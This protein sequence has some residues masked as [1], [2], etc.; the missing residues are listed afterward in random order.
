MLAQAR[1]GVYFSPMLQLSCLYKIVPGRDT[2]TDPQLGLWPSQLPAPYGLPKL[3]R[4]ATVYVVQTV[5]FSLA[6][7]VTHFFMVSRSD[8]L[9]EHFWMR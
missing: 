1:S 6:D 4:I 7:L 3:S 5:H 8:T 9:Q 2:L